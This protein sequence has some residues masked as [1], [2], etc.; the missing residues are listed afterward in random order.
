ME[1]RSGVHVGAF[2]A[3]R[4]AR[5]AAAHEWRITRGLGLGSPTS[6]SQVLG[7]VLEDGVIRLIMRHAPAGADRVTLLAWLT[8]C[9]QEE[10]HWSVRKGSVDG[11]RFRGGGVGNPGWPFTVEDLTSRLMSAVDLMMVEVD[12]CIEVGGGP[13]L[14]A[15][16]TGERI[17][18][19]PALAMVHDRSTRFLTAGLLISMKHPRPRSQ[20][21]RSPVLPSTTPKRGSRAALGQGPENR[22][23]S[24]H[25]PS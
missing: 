5:G 1:A 2:P 24:A 6:P 12:R 16:R 10:A 13:Y 8:A 9:A 14:D 3:L 7:H 19:V 18:E 25:V 11:T 15:M 21:G 20:A 22:A 17:F 23:T 4:T